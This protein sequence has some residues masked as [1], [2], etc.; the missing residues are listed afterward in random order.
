MRRRSA[1]KR[2][3]FKRRR[4]SQEEDEEVKKRER[5]TEQ[6]C[7]SS[8][9]CLSLSN[10]LLLSLSYLKT[11]KQHHSDD[12]DGWNK[13]DDDESIHDG[14]EDETKKQKRSDVDDH[15][16]RRRVRVPGAV[17]CSRDYSRTARFDVC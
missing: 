12:D 10:A 16:Y 6:L 8:F 15:V 11:T 13:D 4:R 14:K 5:N 3:D 2:L 1:E 7:S 9:P 17:E